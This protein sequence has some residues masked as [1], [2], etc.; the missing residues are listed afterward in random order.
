MAVEQSI[1]LSTKTKLDIATGD[2][3]FDP[4]VLDLIN[5]VLSDLVDLGIGDPLGFHIGGDE[6][7]WEDLLGGDGRM[8]RVKTWLFLKVRLLFDPPQTSFLLDLQNKQIDELT[9][10][11]INQR[12]GD[13]WVDPRLDDGDGVII[14]DG[15]G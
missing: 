1:F 14:L 4:Q 12:D 9:W 11:I 6:E 7:R 8:E 2:A 5:G 13:H 3:S 10:R 15:N